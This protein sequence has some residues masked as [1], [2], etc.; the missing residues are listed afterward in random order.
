MRNEMR[1]ITTENAGIKITRKYIKQFYY[2]FIYL[3]FSRAAR[4]AYEGS[5]A[6]GPIGA[7]AA[8]LRQSHSNT[9]SEPPL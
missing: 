4:V 8:T 5:Q 3:V 6:R 2:L 7:V 9:G 1:D